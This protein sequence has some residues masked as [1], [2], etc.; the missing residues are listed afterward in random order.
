VLKIT[1]PFREKEEVLPLLKA[2][3][4]ELYCG[5]LPFEWEK[6]YTDLEFE[7]KRKS[8]C[9]T[10]LKKIKDAVDLAHRKNTPVYL[11]LNGLYVQK[12]YRLLLKVI[13]QLDKVNLDGYIV[14]DIGL[15]LA[16]RG[17]GFNRQLHLSS[18]GT[19]FN[20]EA[21]CFYRKLGVTRIVLERQVSLESMRVI[22]QK[23]PGIEFEAFILNHLCANING[24]C[25]FTHHF[26]I[27]TRQ[28][29]V[30]SYGTKKQLIEAATVYDPDEFSVARSIK[31]A[32]SA[33]FSI[34]TFD[35]KK[36]K[37]A[38]NIKPIF[39]RHLL[40]GVECGA[41]A[42]YDLTKTNIKA[43]KIVGR[44]LGVKDRLVSVRFIRSAL[45]ILNANAGIS[46]QDFVA[47]VKALYR[48]AFGY[49]GRCRGN[50]CYYTGQALA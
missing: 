26:G 10:S 18:L 36:R 31:D 50:N 30:A 43:L 42:L 39:C 27:D 19:A 44:Q 15:L 33:K 11:A 25:A 5:Y 17:L 12:Q 28:K 29:L 3:A 48:Q 13:S 37:V 34:S 49:N 7:Q 16:L 24:F 40:D 14:A 45:D 35:L 2:G 8:G 1:A 22:A 23:N 21:A 9:F 6:A 46:R 32:C 41:C 20:S 47:R 38:R 4:D